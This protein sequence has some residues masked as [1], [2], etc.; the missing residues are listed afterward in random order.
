MRIAKLAS[1]IERVVR[2]NS[3]TIFSALAI[4]G[5][6]TTAYLTGK[7][8]FKACHRL[9]SES[10]HMS[11]KETAELVWKFY[12]PAGVSGAATI[13]CVIAAQKTGSRKT[14]AAQAAFSISERAFSEYRDKVI[15]QIGEN[16]EQKIRDEIAQDHV[17]KNKPPSTEVLVTGPGNILCLEK[18]TGR[19]FSSDAETLKKAQN[20]LNAKLIAHN[21]AY[22]DDFY[23]L[24]GLPQ[25][26][27]SATVGWE[28]DRMM[29]LKFSTTLT[30]D[31]RPC[32]VFDYNYVKP[33]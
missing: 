27:H 17:T 20:D 32:L 31:S 8:S 18:Y 21:Y 3:T 26:S 4:S 6:V 33:I 9:S 29:E 23:Y 10:P 30:P 24:I 12:I 11:K 5:V 7:A 25:T 2:S 16:K 28:S 14:A 1:S 13:A 15:E 19:Y 22:M